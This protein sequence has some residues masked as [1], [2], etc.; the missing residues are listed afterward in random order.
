MAGFDDPITMALL[1]AGGTMMD[2]DGGIGQGM[3]VGMNTLMAGKHMQR[4]QALDQLTQQKAMRKL[5]GDQL[6][7][8][9]LAKQQQAGGMHP[10][11]IGNALIGTGH[12]EL[13]NQGLGI[14]K[15]FRAKSKGVSKV[16]KDGKIYY[17]PNFDD[18]SFGQL[19]ELSAPENLM[20]IDT[21]GQKILA[22]NVTGTPKM[23]FNMGMAPG[24][25]ARL[26][27]SDRQF[28][29]SHNLA[30]Q[31]F[32]LDSSIPFQ[33]QL[34]GAVAG[35]RQQ[36]KNRVDATANL[37]KVIDQANESIGLI[38]DLIS[39]PGFELMVG[40]T[41]PLGE[42]MAFAPGTE[43]RDFKTRFDQIKGK[44]FLEAFET[45]KG[46]GQITEIEGQKATQA[47]SRMERAQSEREFETAARE[48]Q[49]IIRK[50]VERAADKAGVPGSGLVRQPVITDRERKR[51]SISNDGFSSRE[52]P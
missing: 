38:D 18:G 42:I 35:S 15:D 9:T 4:Q 20:Q 1:A 28:N 14:L 19:S 3:Q 52:L 45:L 51:S 33:A 27:Q 13:V 21:G 30:Q 5:E 48:F 8:D 16:E 46:G 7:R 44:Q 29:Q 41:N 11:D 34:Q 50:G 31:R 40:K 22:G 23:A 39:H 37:P 49:D 24:E 12:P 36:A 10:L 32:A 17:Q 6:L 43:A 47:I 25:A 2:P 26:N